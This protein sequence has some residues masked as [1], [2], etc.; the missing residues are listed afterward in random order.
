MRPYLTEE[1]KQACLAKFDTALKTNIYNWKNWYAEN[2]DWPFCTHFYVGKDD[3]E[4]EQN[5]KLCPLYN[6]DRCA[7]EV[8]K[9]LNARTHFDFLYWLR[10]ARD[11][12]A[13]L[14]VGKAE[15]NATD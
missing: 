3:V 13:A 5:H 8:C 12:I 11:I 9:A 10:K 6:G 7:K 4:K 1:V 14:P 15:E 2:K